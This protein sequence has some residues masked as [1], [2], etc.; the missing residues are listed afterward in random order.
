MDSED[1]SEADG[2][3][4]DDDGGGGG[5]DSSEIDF[6]SAY[7]VSLPNLRSLTRDPYGY[8]FSSEDDYNGGM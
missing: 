2:E 7:G 1:D 4:G 8:G 3:D 5:E 6:Q